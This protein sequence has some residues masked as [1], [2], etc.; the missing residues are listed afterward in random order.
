MLWLYVLQGQAC[1]SLGFVPSL[2]LKLL[3]EKL[4]LPCL[5]FWFDGNL[6]REL[7]EVFSPPQFTATESEVSQA[8]KDFFFVCVCAFA[9]GKLPPL[10]FF[11][12]SGRSSL[13]RNGSG[14]FVPSH[15][16]LIFSLNPFANLLVMV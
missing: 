4:F 15:F 16:L 9:G 7:G 6:E 14:M 2:V 3:L 10:F 11:S 13:D 5:R 12:A 8:T 1:L